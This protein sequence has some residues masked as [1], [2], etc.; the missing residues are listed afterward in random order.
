MI[1]AGTLFD[2]RE[3]EPGY[4]PSITSYAD[5]STSNNRII[6]EDLGFPDPLLWYLEG[7]IP[8]GTRLR[9]LGKFL[10]TYLLQ[11]MGIR[12]RSSLVSEEL[13]AI[14]SGRR[15]TNFLPYLGLGTDAADGLL[16]MR[17]G[18]IDIK[19]SH[20][21]S[22]L[23][24]KELEEAMRA[25]SHGANGRYFASPLWRW[26]LRKLPV[27]HPLGGCIM[28]SS[29]KD[30]VVNHHGEVWNYPGLYVA[31]GS[32]I[33]SALSVNPSMTIGAIGERT[34][35]WILHNREMQTDDSETPQ[36]T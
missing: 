27:A 14:M 24:Y 3:V 26:P 9:R 36:K 10:K 4:G 17:D 13:D 2:D 20:R 19:W 7:S 28:G 11:S 29:I 34:A 15:T 33:P 25:F 1:F 35:F 30:S 32:A 16:H 22:R 23:M 8:T 21:G 12:K 6:I 31:D 18:S 5:C